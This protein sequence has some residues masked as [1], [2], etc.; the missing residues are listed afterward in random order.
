MMFFGGG[1][2]DEMFR[3]NEDLPGHD[4]DFATK[5]QGEVFF[6]V[7]FFYFIGYVWPVLGA[8]IWGQSIIKKGGNSKYRFR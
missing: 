4:S 1:F 3:V 8:I 7:N 2:I 5:T 6:A